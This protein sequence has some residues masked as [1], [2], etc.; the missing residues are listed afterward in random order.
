VIVE[1]REL[2]GVSFIK[3]LLEQ[4]FFGQYR[5]TLDS[6]DRLTIP[7][8]FR[9]LV[10]DSVYVS[11]GFD[12]NLLVFTRPY[13]ENLLQTVDESD[14]AD[15]DARLIRRFFF[16]TAELV[17]VDKAGRILI[18]A[19]LRDSVG[20]KGEVVL[21]GAG[22][23]FEIWSPELWDVQ[24]AR[25]KDIGNNVKHFPVLKFRREALQQPVAAGVIIAQQSNESRSDE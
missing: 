25:I 23:Y 14:L 13:F 9:H 4:M 12:H 1:R 7:A 8:R 6:K 20:L 22:Q 2:P 5:H 24:S 21:V 19:F 17:D 15:A 18:P 11:Q 10:G 3:R 16:S